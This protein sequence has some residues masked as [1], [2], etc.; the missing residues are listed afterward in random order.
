MLACES[1]R[2]NVMVL[3]ATDR[4]RAT[5]REDRQRALEGG[6]IV[7]PATKQKVASKHCVY[8]A[9]AEYPKSKEPACA[10]ESEYATFADV[11]VS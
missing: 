1:V 5:K 3:K 4:E 2:Y 10:K 9:S 11:P 7:T 6:L 8:P